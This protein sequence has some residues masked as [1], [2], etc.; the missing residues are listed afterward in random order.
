M[1]FSKH[2]LEYLFTLARN[3]PGYRSLIAFGTKERARD[4]MVLA[5]DMLKTGEGL[6]LMTGEVKFPNGSRIMVDYPDCVRA[7]SFHAVIIDELVAERMAGHLKT[8]ERL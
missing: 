7:D 4:V 1:N 5:K 6:N 2:N 3:R 8:R